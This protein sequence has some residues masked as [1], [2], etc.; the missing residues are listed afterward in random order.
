MFSP[1]GSESN[2]THFTGYIWVNADSDISGGLM[3][4]LGPDEDGVE[5]WEWIEP[6]QSYS[7]D[8]NEVICVRAISLGVDWVYNDVALVFEGSGNYGFFLS[9]AFN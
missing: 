3:G 6:L 7:C 8:E 4:Y 5:V 9:P 2:V 1:D